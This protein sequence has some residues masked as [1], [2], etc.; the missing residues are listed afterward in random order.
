MMNGSRKSVLI[1]GGGTG[2]HIS[3]GIA[4]YEEFT[5]Q[6]VDC[7]LLIGERD[8]KFTYLREVDENHLLHYGA[9]PITKNPFKFP[10]FVLRFL[11]MVMKSRSIMRKKNVSAVIGMGGYVSAP[12]LFA[13]RMK[14]MPYW[15]CEQNTVPGKVTLRFAKKSRAVFTTFADTVKFVKP[16]VGAKCVTVGNPVRSRVK[17]SMSVEDARKVFGLDHCERVVLVIGGSQGALSLNELVVGIK[18]K[19]NEEF[20]RIGIIWCTGAGGYERYCSIAQEQGNMGSVFISP[21]VEDVGVAYRASDLA[22][23]RSGA[24]VMAELAVMGIP[25]ILIPFPYAADDHQNKNADVFARSNA[26]VKLDNKKANPE[27]VA[28][29]VLDILSSEQKLSLMS[30][31]AKAEACPEAA[32]TI[33]SAVLA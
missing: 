23:A 30:R 14:K 7:Y 10:F 29:L 17:V 13:A 25:S 32:K 1:V 20:S 8:R 26:S 18:K 24:G 11:G 6:G 12:M 4:L 2:G 19:F 31:R 3:P 15:L 9:P 28:P 21:F 33:V 22:I 5:A 16:A 27:T